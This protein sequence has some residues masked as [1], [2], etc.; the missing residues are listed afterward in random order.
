[1]ILTHPVCIGYKN[2][3]DTVFRI[4]DH[5]TLKKKRI[6]F[7]IPIALFFLF[8][9]LLFGVSEPPPASALAPEEI[10][11]LAN[12][13]A[14]S[15]RGLAAYYMEKR[16]IPKENLAVVFVT[17]DETCSRD[18]YVNKVVP[19]VRRILAEKPH[20]RA[21][22]TMYGMPLRIAAPE[23]TP[24]EKAT[25][26]KLVSQQNALE[27]Q[28]KNRSALGHDDRTKKQAQLSA[29]KKRIQNFKKNTNKGASFDSELMLVKKENYSLNMWLPNPFFLGW[30]DKASQIQKSEVVMVSR[31]D[32]ASPDIVK[33]IINDTI[34]AEAEGLSGTAYFDARWPYPEKENI[35]GYAL[36]D[37]SIHRAS[38]AISKKT[39]LNVVLN[40]NN[41]LFQRGE[42]PN[43]ALYCGWY[44]LATYV[45]AFTWQKGSVG[46][47]I[48]SAECTTLKKQDSTVWCKKML[49][50]GVA[51]T[52]GPVGEPYVQSFPMPEIFFDFLAEGYL[53]LA[54]SYLV[55]LP[56]LSWKMVLVGDPLYYVNIEKKAPPDKAT[57]PAGETE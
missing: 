7:R 49:D 36:Y 47:H 16:Q 37:R 46:L 17:D 48:A 21:I 29:I 56:F 13:N 40:D 43:A 20:L 10:L 6:M 39:R 5:V 52:V 34:E 18:D 15:S 3:D 25:L 1:M 23:Q 35:S 32:A 4:I 57:G 12:M 51:A 31:L 26:D 41:A 11:V 55:S 33:R 14:S 38:T 19:K 8:T 42:A 9:V 45:D 24:E 54:E 30:G 44:S 50:N 53:S 27:D 2:W 28:L 22:V